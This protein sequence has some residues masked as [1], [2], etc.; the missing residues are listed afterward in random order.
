MSPLPVRVACRLLV[1]AGGLVTVAMVQ[2]APPV[3]ADGVLLRYAFRQDD[4][5]ASEVMHRALTETTMNGVTQTVE[6]S[7]DSN[8][9]WKVVVVDD[10]GTAVLEQVVDEVTMT[11]RSSDHGEL[12]WS[13]SGLAD[14]PPGYE[15]VRQSLGVP[16]VRLQVAADGRILE[17]RELLPCP[18]AATGDLVIVPLPEEPV[19][20]GHEW[21][22]PDEVVVE[23]PNGPRRAVRT[24]LR[25]RLEKLEDGIATIAVDTTVLTP[26]DDPRLEAR[27][28]ERI[29]DGTVRFD[30]EAGRIVGRRTTIDRRVVGFGG[31]QSSLRYKASLEERLLDD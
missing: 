19:A 13:S 15:G 1:I 7:T 26:V 23:V 16:L 5:L 24:R 10:E 14:P 31:P 22:V 18:T 25:Y 17:R 9:T 11:S 28:L 27:L 21:T 8:R 3:A 2:A 29:W 6:T 12:R 4:D 20:V 30:V